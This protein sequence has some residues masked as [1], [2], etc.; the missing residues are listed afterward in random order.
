M[1]RRTGRSGSATELTIP[2]APVPGDRKVAKGIVRPGQ[3][4]IA[5]AIAGE[6]HVAAGW[7]L[8]ASVD[9]CPN[10]F[11]VRGVAATGLVRSVR[12]VVVAQC[13]SRASASPSRNPVSTGIS[14][15]E[16]SSAVVYRPRM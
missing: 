16:V 8:S 6:M 14:R 10:D 13:S 15:R 4:R 11:C 3:H 5:K 9:P 2:G 7:S 1:Q 12:C